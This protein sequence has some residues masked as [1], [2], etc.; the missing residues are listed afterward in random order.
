MD[1]GAVAPFHRRNI[2]TALGMHQSAVFIR[3]FASA[4][5]LCYS[6]YVTTEFVMHMGTGLP[7]YRFCITALRCMLG[8]M[9][10]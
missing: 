7:L 8:V 5:H 1:M 2:A 10:T 6:F 9:L 3:G 4:L